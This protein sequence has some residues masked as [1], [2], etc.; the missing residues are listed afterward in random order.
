VAANSLVT[1][2][3]PPGATVAGVPA[4]VVR[5][6]DGT[7]RDSVAGRADDGHRTEQA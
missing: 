1:E 4:D 6:G 3:V 2:D 7:P 5:R